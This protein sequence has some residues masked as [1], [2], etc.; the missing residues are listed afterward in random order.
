MPNSQEELYTVIE[1]T[2]G[3]ERSVGFLGARGMTLGIGEV[4]AVPGDLVA[5][6]GVQAASGQR[7]KFDALQ[8]SLV[9]GRLA[10]RSR[11]APV[12]WDSDV[13]EIKSLAVFDGALGLVDPEYV[14]A[15]NTNFDAV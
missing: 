14:A 7:R 8:R 13:D 6:L 1:N 15:G 3:S 2:S 9:A 11:P 10:I 4:V 5:T 12:F